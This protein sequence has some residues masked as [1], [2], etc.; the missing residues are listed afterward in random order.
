MRAFQFATVVA[1]TFLTA[2]ASQAAVFSVAAAPEDYEVHRQIDTGALATSNGVSGSLRVGSRTTGTS[3]TSATPIFPFALPAIPAGEEIISATFS[4]VTNSQTGNL[5]TA[6]ADLYGLPH[7]VAPLDILT[8]RYFLGSNDTTAGVSKLEDDFLLPGD[9]SSTMTRYESVD[10]QN[11][12]ESLYTAGAVAGD[13]AI[14]RLS[15]DTD[16]LSLAA[17]NRFEVRSRQ[18]TSTTENPEAQWPLLVITTAPIPE[19]ASVGLLAVGALGLLRRR[20][21][22]H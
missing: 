4:V 1:A 22:S 3:G 7:D 21:P 13:F 6:N 9:L 10:I 17:H 16:S 18:A 19:P 20:R 14:L 15:Y 8:S 11:Y 12:I 2:S 5:P